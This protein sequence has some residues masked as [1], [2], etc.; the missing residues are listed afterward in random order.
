[1]KSD[2]TIRLIISTFLLDISSERKWRKLAFIWLW[3]KSWKHA[4][5]KCLITYIVLRPMGQS[6][7]HSLNRNHFIEK[8]YVWSS[9]LMTLISNKYWIFEINH[10]KN[11]FEIFWSFKFIDLKLKFIIYRYIIKRRFVC[12]SM[13][14]NC[15]HFKSKSITYSWP[16]GAVLAIHFREK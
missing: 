9:F 10:L 15:G 2:T 4:G 14:S 11:R 16:E 3:W 13:H 5:D 6:Y 12:P 8:P 1:M 7:N